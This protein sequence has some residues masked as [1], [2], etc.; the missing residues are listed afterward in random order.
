LPP[1]GSPLTK[2]ISSPIASSSTI[3]PVLDVTVKNAYPPSRASSANQ[4]FESART[5]CHDLTEPSANAT[6]SPALGGFHVPR[7]RPASTGSSDIPDRVLRSSEIRRTSARVTVSSPRSGWRV[8]GATL[9]AGVGAA[10]AATATTVT[11]ALR[12]WRSNGSRVRFTSG[13]SLRSGGDDALTA[14]ACRRASLCGPAPAFG[15]AGSFA[16]SCVEHEALRF[17]QRAPA[18]RVTVSW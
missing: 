10:T 18:L 15:A 12:V 3:R 17:R 1:R 2:T 5:G 11:A 13:H 9:P 16:S 4:P 7:T 6:D 8:V 14:N